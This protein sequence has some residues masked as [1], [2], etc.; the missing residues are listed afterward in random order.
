MKYRRSII[1]VAGTLVAGMAGCLDE[2]SEDDAFP[3]DDDAGS[4]DDATDRSSSSLFDVDDPPEFPQTD[5]RTDPS[6]ETN[7]LHSQIRGNFDFTLALLDQF[8]STDSGANLVYSPYSVSVALAMTYAGARGQTAEEMANAVHYE[9][10]GESLHQ[11]FSSLEVEFSRRNEDGQDVENPVG[12]DPDGPAFELRSANRVWGEE[13]Y[14]FDVDFIE[15]LSTYYGAGMQLL[16]FID[17]SEESRQIINEWIESETH[18]KID[19]LLPSSA[20]DPNTKLVL[21]NAVYFLGMWKFPFQE[22]Q[23]EQGTFRNIDGTESS[24]SMMN[25]TIEVPYADVEGHQAVELPYANDDT[26]MVIIVPEAGTFES[27][28]SSLTTDH[29]ATFLDAMNRPE[30]E[31]RMPAFEV[32]TEASLVEIMQNLG[33]ERP[34]GN[35]D[36]GDMTKGDENPGLFIDDILHESVIAVDELG[37]EAA[38]ATAVTMTDSAPLD[39]VELTIDRPFLY[40]IRDRPT[41]TPLFFGRVVDGDPLE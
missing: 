34:F 40:F 12:E 16:D 11:V 35:A 3:N 5:F 31:L 2:S 24:V 7:G 18:G 4:N 26:S 17:A 6:I 30:V 28:E 23:T 8:V 22:S 32:E 15:L 36:F 9:L 39:H 25:Q 20:I 14:P 27:I 19:E 37:T 38:A 10:T 1:A 33:M 13:S 21:T 41:E 29:I